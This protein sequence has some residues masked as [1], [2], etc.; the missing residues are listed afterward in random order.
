M[1]YGYG[2]VENP[3]PETVIAADV[4]IN[5]LYEKWIVINIHKMS[6]FVD[7]KLYNFAFVKLFIITGFFF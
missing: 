3:L 4:R 6:S 2:D 5:E 1:L 7:A